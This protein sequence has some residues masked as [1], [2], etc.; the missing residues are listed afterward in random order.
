MSITKDQLKF[1]CRKCEMSGF[2][3]PPDMP[4]SINSS[5]CSLVDIK[6]SIKRG[7]KIFK[8][9]DP[10]CGLYVVKSG[11]FKYSHAEKILAF[12]LPGDVF[13]FDAI[14]TEAY[15]A[16]ATA[17]EDSSICHIPTIKLMEL[18]QKNPKLQTDILKLLS[19]KVANNLDEITHHL[20]AEQKLT[21]FLLRLAKHHAERGFSKT[22]FRL[23]MTRKDIANY[24]DL[25]T[26]TVSR[27]LADLQ[28]DG[29]LRVQH[30][31]I[32]ILQPEQLRA[33]ASLLA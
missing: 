15:P 30:K 21:A 18:L 2:C 20:T 9:N 29:T 16:T 22:A 1:S 5:I 3:F 8:E 12:Y 26:E 24:L 14:H 13:G 23:A 28:K 10:F 32:E 6:L 27:I 17:I 33:K 19:K 31:D 11:A 4:S 7:E 25:A